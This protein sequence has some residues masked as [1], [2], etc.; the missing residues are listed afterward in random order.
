MNNKNMKQKEKYQLTKPVLCDNDLFIL[1]CLNL[2]FMHFLYYSF[3]H[4]ISYGIYFTIQS[5]SYR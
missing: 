2:K 1:K 5:I 3:Y 4:K